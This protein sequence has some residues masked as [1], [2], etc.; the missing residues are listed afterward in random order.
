MPTVA[1]AKLERALWVMTFLLA[2][3]PLL[4][5]WLFGLFDLDEGFYATVTREM[6]RT[7]DWIT[8][9]FNGEPWFDLS[10]KARSIGILAAP[11]AH[12]PELLRLVRK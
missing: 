5:W 4:G 7:G 6:L 10:R 12:H 3:L 8:P 2:A 11:A 1:G 9:H